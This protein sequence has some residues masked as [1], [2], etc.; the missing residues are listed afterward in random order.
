MNEIGA[1]YALAVAEQMSLVGVFLGGV[2]ITILITIVVFSSPK[3]S[4]NWIVATSALAACSL[5]V[6]VIS[7]LR[8]IIVLHPEFPGSVVTSSQS[9]GWLWR[10]MIAGYGIGV[11]GLVISIGLSGW[12]RSRGTGLVTATIAIVAVMFFLFTSPFN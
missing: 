6:S 5:L 11:L 8:L 3:K 10:S 12:L 4:V 9:I 2:S 7:S 1:S